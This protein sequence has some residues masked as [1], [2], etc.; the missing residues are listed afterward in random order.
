MLSR[1]ECDLLATTIRISNFIL[2]LSFRSSGFLC[3]TRVLS[4]TPIITADSHQT[5]LWF[6]RINHLTS[7]DKHFWML[8]LA[9][10]SNVDILS[11]KYGYLGH[12][13]H[14]GWISL[15]IQNWM[16]RTTRFV[17]TLYGRQGVTRRSLILMAQKSPINLYN[18]C[19]C[20]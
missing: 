13:S 3:T 16:P 12:K 4:Q 19:R 15:P 6:S 7:P 1:L 10:K 20:Q 14:A 18:N 8:V 17:S 9:A 5:T 2:K 11:Q